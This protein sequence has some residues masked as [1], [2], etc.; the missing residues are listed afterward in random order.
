MTEIA[1]ADLL[2][3]L[4]GIG[5]D[6]I[7]ALARAGIHRVDDLD[8]CCAGG[9]AIAEL[10]RRTGIADERLRRWLGR[11]LLSTVA[12]AAGAPDVQSRAVRER[13][14]GE[15]ARAHLWYVSD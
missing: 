13:T 2:E 14:A 8:G 3:H 4:E 1:L 15:S 6:E 12:P 5:A 9:P 10:S 11:P 7:R